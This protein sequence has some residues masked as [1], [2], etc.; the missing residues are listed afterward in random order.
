[1]GDGQE[2]EHR[3]GGASHGDVKRHGIE[4]GLTGGDGERQYAF[5]SVPIVFISVFHDDFSRIHEE[6]FPVLV[7]RH[8]ATVAGQGEADGLVEAVHGVG[9]E[10]SRAGAAGRAGAVLD[11]LQVFV[12]YGGVRR[13]DHG[14]DQVQVLVFPDTRLHRSAGDEDGRDVQTHGGE[15]HARSYLVAVADA[16]ERVRLVGVDHVFHTVRDEVPGW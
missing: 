5:V 4:E 12:G 8:D 14:V 10:H 2:M 6:V 3:V 7:G 9:G 13:F 11:L 16:D 15:Q 1:M